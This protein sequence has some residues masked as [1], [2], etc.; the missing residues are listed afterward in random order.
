MF[1]SQVEKA[2]SIIERQLEIRTQQESHE[3]Q[4][5]LV[6]QPVEYLGRDGGAQQHPE[7][8]GLNNSSF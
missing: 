5:R 7:S 3:G 4:V 1:L 2:R 8:T 6:K